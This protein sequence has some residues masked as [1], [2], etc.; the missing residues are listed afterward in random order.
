MVSAIVRGAIRRTGLGQRI[1]DWIDGVEGIQAGDTEIGKGV[2]WLVMFLV[3]VAIFQV[4]TIATEPLNN[5]LNQ[6]FQFISK[7]IGAAILIIIA[8]IITTVV[9]MT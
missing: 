1:A 6:V 2:F 5:F 8:W 7:M 9:R 4:L 3:F